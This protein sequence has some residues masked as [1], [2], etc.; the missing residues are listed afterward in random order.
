MFFGELKLKLLMVNTVSSIKDYLITKLISAGIEVYVSVDDLEAIELM[1]K[2][3]INIILVDIDSKKTD[4]L[5]FIKTARKKEG[6]ENLRSIIITKTIEK[7]VL[8]EYIQHGLIGIL[9][10]SMDINQFDRKIINWIDSKVV[11]EERRKNVRIKPDVRDKVCVRL[12]ITGRPSEKV[13]GSVIDLSIQGVAFKFNNP[14]DKNYFL[15]NQQIQHVE[16]DIEGRRYLTT[17]TMVRVSEVSVGVFTNPKENF[18]SSI[19]KY[20]F[21]KL[22]SQIKKLK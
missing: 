6:Y 14:E 11:E 18:I 1:D 15:L 13:E 12:P 16:I 7:D 4:Y 8:A 21:D 5:S 17:L 10:K 22:E 3:H 2:I 20:L 19:A 9:T